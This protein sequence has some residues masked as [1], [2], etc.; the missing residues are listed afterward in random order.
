MTLYAW[1]DRGCIGKMLLFY[2]LIN[3]VL[4]SH[5][6]KN[7]YKQGLKH[8]LMQMNVSTPRLVLVYYKLMYL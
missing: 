1:T 5:Y 2:L 7:D 4:I 8:L 3:E 6:W